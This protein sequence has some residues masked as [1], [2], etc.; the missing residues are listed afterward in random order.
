MDDLSGLATQQNGPRG[1]DVQGEP[2]HRGEEQ[3]GREAGHL[4]RVIDL[5]GGKEDEKSDRKTGRQENI[6]DPV[7]HGDDQNGQYA[8]D[9]DRKN[10]LILGQEGLDDSPSHGLWRLV[11]HL[12]RR[13][14]ASQKQTDA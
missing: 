11:F 1:T 5:E 7:G 12:V 2:E 14:S 8:D 6:D 4:Q 13:S 9:P 10:V 3:Q